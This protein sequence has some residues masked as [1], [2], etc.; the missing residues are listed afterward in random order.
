M[1]RSLQ[2]LARLVTPPKKRIA[3]KLRTPDED[4]R[5]YGPQEFRDWLHAQ[6][7]AFCLTWGVDQAHAT[8]DGAG[9][10]ASWKFSFPACRPHPKKDHPGMSEGCHRK[11]HRVGVKT[12]E[13]AFGISLLDVAKQTQRAWEAFNG[14]AS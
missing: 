6:P 1:A 5:I 3:K 11:I 10:K 4:L 12:F 8:V 7:C 13:K 2:D 14:A 9:R